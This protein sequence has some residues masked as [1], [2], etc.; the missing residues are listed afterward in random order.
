MLMAYG[1]AHGDNEL[2]QHAM[3]WLV[4]TAQILSIAMLIGGGIAMQ[5]QWPGEAYYILGLLPMVLVSIW[6]VWQKQWLRNS[7]AKAAG[8]IGLSLAVAMS[9]SILFLTG[10]SVKGIDHNKISQ[11]LASSA[12]EAGFDG[13]ELATFHYFQPSL[14]FYHGGRLPMLTKV[15]QVG[16]WLVAGKA[17]V[18]SQNALE[19]L[20]KEIIPYLIVHARVHGM[21][22]RRWLLLVSLQPLPTK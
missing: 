21:Y 5:K 12:T 7:N 11:T 6:L 1:W 4:W 19:L 2:R 20:P 16:A 22:A 15:E 17:V 9:V 8:I 14:L 13:N 3:K 10:W 18:I